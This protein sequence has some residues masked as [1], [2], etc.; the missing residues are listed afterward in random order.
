MF[1]CYLW[2]PSRIWHTQHSSVQRKHNEWPS[3]TPFSADKSNAN[4]FQSMINN[5]I[6]TVRR[7][8]RVYF[9]AWIELFSPFR[10]RLHH[11]DTAKHT[12]ENWEIEQSSW[13]STNSRCQLLQY[14]Y[15]LHD[16]N[17]LY[18]LRH[19]RYSRAR[20]SRNDEHENREQKLTLYIFIKFSLHCTLSH[21]CH[22]RP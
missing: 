17:I 13:R 21:I 9:S 22:R 12:H 14:A 15:H 18:H 19:S 1:Q 10:C 4:E 2:P 7:Y 6:T 3:R 5:W 8:N 20:Q 16:I 11:T